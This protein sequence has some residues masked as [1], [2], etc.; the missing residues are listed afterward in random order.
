MPHVLLPLQPDQVTAIQGYVSSGD[1]AD[2]YNYVSGLLA[3]A[4][5]NNDPAMTD[6]GRWFD[7]ASQ[8]NG[9]SG[10]FGSFARGYLESE[11]DA[12]GVTVTDSDFQ[13]A[14]NTLAKQVLTEIVDQGG[15][16]DAQTI[17]PQDV[18]NMESDLG[19][20]NSAWPGGLL[21]WV[22]LGGNYASF[23]DDDGNP[24]QTTANFVNAMNGVAAG[25]ARAIKDGF[26]AP[27]DLFPS[28][29]GPNGPFKNLNSGSIPFPTGSPLIGGMYLPG[30]SA[31]FNS[32]MVDPIVLDLGGTGVQLVSLQ[33]SQ[34]YFDLY[35]TGFAVHT[36]WVGPQTGILVEDKNGD[37]SI[38]NITELFGS[39]ST[40]GFAAL[41]ALDANHDGV[42]NAL[43]PGFAN[44]EVWT[45]TNGNGVSLRL[46][47][48]PCK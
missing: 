9:D 19:L 28:L 31:A 27:G 10:F 1:Y 11:A 2:G 15:I 8:I 43:D 48:A 29:F 25:I 46:Q 35:N 24:V 47:V 21:D 5:V 33:N 16:P 39:A 4:N 38:N 17:V 30:I 40:D 32:S 6:A 37:G 12:N 23:V 3:D 20:P 44:L 22:L 26:P 18:A 14:S 42:I 41:D 7:I 36:G 13:N 45:D 34:A